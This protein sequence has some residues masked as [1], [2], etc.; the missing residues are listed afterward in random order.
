MTATI[1]VQAAQKPCRITTVHPVGRAA[2]A[3]IM[4]EPG[5]EQTIHIHDTQSLFVEE[6]QPGTAPA[7][8]FAGE[9]PI[10]RFFAYAH[11]P[12]TLR[13]VS[14]PFAE[15]A[16]TLC[17]I[18]SRGPERSVALRKLLESKDAAVRSAL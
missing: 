9:E 18:L 11:L 17:L 3:P 10:L 4:V 16:N 2:T 8:D 13:E 6:L 12:E 7:I 15:L 14:R 5:H 1:F